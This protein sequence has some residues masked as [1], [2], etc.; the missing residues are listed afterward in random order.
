MLASDAFKSERCFLG[1]GMMCKV[2][3]N[4]EEAVMIVGNSEEAT[5]QAFRKLTGTE[6]ILDENKFCRVT[7]TGREES[8]SLPAINRGEEP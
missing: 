7:I 4:E 2:A 6:P 8:R 3:E 1:Y 5:K